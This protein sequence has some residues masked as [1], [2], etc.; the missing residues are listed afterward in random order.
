MENLDEMT[1]EE[2]SSE[3]LENSIKATITAY[4]EGFKLSSPEFNWVKVLEDVAKEEYKM[5]EFFKKIKK[6][7][8]KVAGL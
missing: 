5:D 6:E 2:L 8:K 7:F 3:L 4:I 1:T